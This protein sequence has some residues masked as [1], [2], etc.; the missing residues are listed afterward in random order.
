MVCNFFRWLQVSLQMTLVV[1]LVRGPPLK[2]FLIKST[3]IFRPL[4]FEDLD[5]F[6]L[7]DAK[8]GENL[9]TLKNTQATAVKQDNGVIFL[10][11][12]TKGEKGIFF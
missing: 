2:A 10:T 9:V 3:K 11:P 12:E 5:V 8:K 4:S 7:Q 1:S 6:S